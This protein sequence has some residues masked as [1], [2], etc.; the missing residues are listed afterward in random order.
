MPKGCGSARDTKK[1][2]RRI[3]FTRPCHSDDA[4]GSGG[5]CAE[6]LGGF[7]IVKQQWPRGKLRKAKQKSRV[8][9]RCRLIA[10]GKQDGV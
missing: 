7:A 2:E 9:S 6:F 10:L 5:K 3:R 1:G 4:R 8:H